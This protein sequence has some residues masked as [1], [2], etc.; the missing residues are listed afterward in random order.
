MRLATL[1][2]YAELAYAPG[3]APAMA[4]LRRNIDKIP[5]GR[6]EGSRYWVD[7]DENDRINGLRSAAE[8]RREELRKDPLLADLI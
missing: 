3:S 6:K 8:T 4:T 7:L 2:A 5:G 1:R